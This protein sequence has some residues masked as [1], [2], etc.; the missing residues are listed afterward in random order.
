MKKQILSVALAFAML[1][2][3]TVSNAATNSSIK[4]V[5]PQE[6][7]VKDFN[8]QFEATP[9]IDVINKGFIASSV[10]D[11]HKVSSAYN[12]RGRRIYTIVRYSYDNL[13]KNVL[14]TVKNT[15]AKCFITSMEKVSQPG[16][17]PVFIVHLSDNHS[18]KTVK[19]T[20][21]NIMLL[22]DFSNI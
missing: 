18:L 8:K 11:G 6:K 2:T 21:D 1:A 10:V 16:F 13:D 7:I 14:E 17:D 12:A 3:A 22:Q 20:G 9:A 5:T 15:Y 4:D 19:V